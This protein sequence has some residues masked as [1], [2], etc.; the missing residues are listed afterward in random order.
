MSLLGIK[1][2]H[3]VPPHNDLKHVAGDKI[4]V[5]GYCKLSFECSGRKIVEDCYLLRA[6]QTKVE[7]LWNCHVKQ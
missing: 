6:D 4:K 3:L 1:R 7:Q 2:K 5:I